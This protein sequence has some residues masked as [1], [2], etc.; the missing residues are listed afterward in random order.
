MKE[1][2]ISQYI[3]RDYLDISQ[4]WQIQKIRIR[5]SVET[6]FCC[7]IVHLLLWAR[8]YLAMPRLHSQLSGC[9]VFTLSTCSCIL[10]LVFY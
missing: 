4:V 5:L 2:N 3:H 1:Y 10:V 9:Q 7:S 6:Q 8:K